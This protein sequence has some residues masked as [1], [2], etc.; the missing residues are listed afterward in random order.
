MGGDG[1]LKWS[2][3]ERFMIEG[4][5]SWGGGVDYGQVGDGFARPVLGEAAEAIGRA[6]PCRPLPW[7]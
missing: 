1:R 2:R 7:E 3:S 5:D 6:G 4:L